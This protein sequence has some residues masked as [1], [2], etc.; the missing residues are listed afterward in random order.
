VIDH[1]PREFS[2]KDV[3]KLT[4]YRRWLELVINNKQLGESHE[5]LL[6]DLDA[7]R[8]ESL[9]DPLTGLWNRRGF[10]N[11]VARELAKS[12]REQGPIALAMID[13]DLFKK[14]NDTYGHQEGDKAL[15]LLSRILQNRIRAYDVLARVGGEEF[16]V[17]LPGVRAEHAARIAEKLRAGVEAGAVLDSG[18][19]FTISVGLAWFDGSATPPT[20]E[21]MVARADAALYA[22]KHAGRNRAIVDLGEAPGTEVARGA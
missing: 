4:D 21:L 14:I 20:E 9:V 7:A 8:R 19:R 3:Q 13:V 10:S 5:Q 6:T 11:I 1:E 18:A 17:L 15:G 22:A 12:A 2:K 16:A